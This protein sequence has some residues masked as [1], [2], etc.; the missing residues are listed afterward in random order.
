MTKP[1]DVVVWIGRSGKR[2]AVTVIGFTL[3]A[4]GLVMLVIPGPGLL[5]IVAGLAVLA[6]EYAWARRT[7]EVAKKRA[8]D[9]G[10]R[11]RRRR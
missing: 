11:L 9:V 2:I 5:V 3:V 8:G 1:R 6:S 10:R 7:L 4:A